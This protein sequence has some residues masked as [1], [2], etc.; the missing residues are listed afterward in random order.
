MVGGLLPVEDT[1]AGAAPR[2]FGESPDPVLAGGRR[3]PPNGRRDPMRAMLDPV[4]QRVIGVLIEKERTVPDSYPLTEAQLIAGCNQK[5]NRDPEMDL[6]NTE[7]HPALLALR[8]DGWVARVEGNR[9]TRYRHR[10]E[11]RLN[12]NA[13]EQAV[14]CELLCRGPQAPGK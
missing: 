2:D 1:D 13:D 4:Q 6:D 3:L 7:L 9:A 8:E 5:S 11:E 10:V 14:L 12:V